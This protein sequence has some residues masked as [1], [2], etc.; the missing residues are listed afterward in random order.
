METFRGYG[1]E[2][3]WVVSGRVS[4]QFGGI[5]S[6]VKGFPAELLGFLLRWLRWGLRGVEVSG[7]AGGVTVTT[8]TNT[9]GFFTLHFER[10]EREAQRGQWQ[11]VRITVQEKRRPPLHTRETIFVPSSKFEYIVVSDLDDT[12]IHTGVAQRLKMFWRLFFRP[13]E[14][15]VAYPGVSALYQGFHD[16]AQG[17]AGNPMLY[18]SRGP[19]SIYDMLSEFF[20]LH[21][22]PAGPVLMLRDWG[23][24]LRRPWP[25]RALDHKR[26]AIHEILET[27]PEKPCILLGDSGQRDPEIY[28]EIVEAFPGRVRAVYIRNVSRGEARAGAIRELALELRKDGSHLILANDSLTIAAH[29][30]ALGLVAES[31]VADVRAAQSS[32][33]PINRASQ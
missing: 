28:A 33:P 25:R 3:R 19:W 2:D 31:V 18:V 22:I 4:R 9:E 10:T 32:T 12:V 8:R 27:Y 30:A 29:A 7:R 5:P 24:S 6:W 26:D 14:S 23:M 21:R 16:G 1:S 20:R 15:R 17:N 13:A 11:E